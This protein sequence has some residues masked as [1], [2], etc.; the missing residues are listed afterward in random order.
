MS[1]QLTTPRIRVV[2][3]DGAG[4]LTEHEFQA[5]NADMVA[6]DRERPR[7]GWP[8]ADGAPIL[9][10]TFL[11]WKA[12]KRTGI[13]DVSLKDFEAAALQVEVIDPDTVEGGDEVDPTQTAVGGE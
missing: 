3:Q 10:V 4:E 2:L 8:Q 5:I 7:Y 9:W 13:L 11:A 12:C 6:W 1:A